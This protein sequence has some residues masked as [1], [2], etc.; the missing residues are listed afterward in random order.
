MTDPNNQNFFDPAAPAET[1]VVPWWQNKRTLLIGGG[2][3]GGVVVL[4]L[5]GVFAYQT[6][7]LNSDQESRLVEA[8]QLAQETMAE[9]DGEDDVEACKAR[10]RTV[11][12]EQTGQVEVCEGLSGQQ[13]KNCVVLIARDEADPEACDMLQGDD[14]TSC[15]D[16]AYLVKAKDNDDANFCGKIQNDQKRESCQ[17]QVEPEVTSELDA[18]VESGNPQD[19]AALSGGQKAACEDA[20][21]SLDRDADGLSRFEESQLGTSDDNQDTDGDGYSDGQ[22]VSA[23][24]DPLN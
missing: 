20:Y 14:K 18:A 17:R 24:Y 9:C 15:E 23:G 8:E 2:A 12:A 16:A 6:W 4:G 19:C 10:A 21:L 13:L 22:E 1:P 11:A 7:S 5:I 3:L